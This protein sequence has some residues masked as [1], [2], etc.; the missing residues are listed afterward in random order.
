MTRV[1]QV[2]EDWTV[3]LCSHRQGAFG[4]MTGCDEEADCVEIRRDDWRLASPRCSGHQKPDPDRWWTVRAGHAAEAQQIMA[5]LEVLEREAHQ[6]SGGEDGPW[7]AEDAEVVRCAGP[8]QR[9]L[10]ERLEALCRQ[11]GTPDHGEIPIRGERR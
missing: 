8:L 3:A 1:I 10:R 6:A 4:R 9:R 7:N 2:K 5:A 11:S